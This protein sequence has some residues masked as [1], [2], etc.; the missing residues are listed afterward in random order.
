[1][2]ARALARRRRR[3]ARHRPRRHHVVHR[4]HDPVARRLPRR[5]A[6]LPPR[7]AP[8]ADHGARLRGRRGGAGARARLPARVPRRRACWSSPSSCRASACSATTRRPRNLVSTALFGDGAAAAVLEGARRRRHADRGGVRVLETLAHIFPHSTDALGFDLQ[9]RR[10]SLGALQGRARPPQ[11]RDRGARANAGG[12]PRPRTRGADL[13]RAPPGRPEDPRRR[14]G[15]AGPAARGHASRRGTCCATSA[16]SRAR[17]CCSCCT[18]G[19]ARGGRR[20]GRHG[21]LAAF[22]PGSRPRC[23]CS[24]GPDA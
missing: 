6:R 24:N 4:D 17:R 20:A 15:G 14:R 12:A 23:C 21:L 22:G 9:R 10:L 8:A 16:T 1:M 2:A 7:R 13:L 11:E 19:S 18:S 3:A 5:R